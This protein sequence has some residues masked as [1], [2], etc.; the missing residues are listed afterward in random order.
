[1]RHFVIFVFLDISNCFNHLDHVS[2]FNNFNLFINYSVT[3]ISLQTLRVAKF[4]GFS[5]FTLSQCLINYRHPQIYLG[6]E[7]NSRKAF[8]SKF[9]TN[10]LLR[11][12]ATH[13]AIIGNHQYQNISSE[14]L[15]VCAKT[16]IQRH[17][18][19]FCA[20]QPSL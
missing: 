9:S 5:L 10:Y 4:F 1:M 11:S 8:T 14:A 3:L 6:S 12:K 15:E 16:S 19:I 2:I 13:T 20:E 7:R 17:Y 18:N